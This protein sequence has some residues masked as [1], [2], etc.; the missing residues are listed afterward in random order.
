[1]YGSHNDNFHSRFRLKCPMFILLHLITLVQELYGVEYRLSRSQSIFLDPSVFF[2][3]LPPPPLLKPP[4]IYFIFLRLFTL[5]PLDCFPS[6]LIWNYG[7]F[8]QCVDS[9]VRWS[10][11]PT[12]HKT[13]HRRNTRPHSCLEWGSNS[14]SQYFKD[15]K[16][17]IL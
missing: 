8:K 12:G 16:H 6:E 5:S 1:M 10:A 15:K 9:L 2:P 4:Y 17:F 13:K 14:R 7:S 11:L 3:P